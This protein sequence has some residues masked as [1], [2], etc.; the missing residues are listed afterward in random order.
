MR[1]AVL[2][3]ERDPDHIEPAG[4][5]VERGDPDQIEDRAE[6]V[7]ER[8]DGRRPELPSILAVAHQ[9]VGRDHRNLEE[10]VKVEDV[11]REED[12][13]QTGAQEKHK[14]PGTTANRTPP[15]TS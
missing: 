6:Q 9:N 15:I 8:E 12:T 3:H 10:D 7:D 11:G 4:N 14:A 1:L 2:Q 5:V 13:G